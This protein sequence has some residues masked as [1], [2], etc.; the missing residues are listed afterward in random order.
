MKKLFVLFIVACSLSACHA[1]Q[2][3]VY[4]QYSK[5]REG[6]STEDI[7]QPVIKRGDLLTI[8]ISSLT[9]E[10][11]A[12]FNPPLIPSGE[13]MNAYSV[14]ERLGVTGG[15][16]LQN[17]LINPDGDLIFPV[18]GKL[19]VV[20]LTKEALGNL[21]KSKIYPTYIKDEPII[22]IRYADFKVSVLGE[23]TRPGKIMV[24]NERISIL[25]AIAQAGD[26]TVY[27]RRDNVLLIREDATGKRQT[28]NV[29]LRDKS[30]LSSPYYF[31]Q[32]NDVLYVE[33][34]RT[35]SR[36]RFFGVAESVSVSI[37]GTL[38]SLTSLI[39]TLTR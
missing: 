23:V 15:V 18:I 21:I 10:A 9:P 29:D 17:Y 25:E 31:L 13:A 6:L 5:E 28:I 3:T 8:T 27:G 19:H 16:S 1:Y 30:V 14:N 11:V 22:Q 35:R 32:Q 34:N 39:V 33:P 24:N 20:G 26:L 7:P 37:V 4:F 38:I 2:E 12:P 36:A